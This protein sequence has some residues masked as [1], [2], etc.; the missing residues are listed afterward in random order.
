MQLNNLQ[1]F[2][3]SKLALLFAAALSVLALGCTRKQEN[4]SQVIVRLPVSHD[5]NSTSNNLINPK[6]HFAKIAKLEAM[7]SADWGIAHPASLAETKCFAVVV[8]VPTGTTSTLSTPQCAIDSN[9]EKNITVS[10]FAGLAP[11]GSEIELNVAAGPDRTF[12]LFAF[13]AES[14]GDCQITTVGSLI[15]KS[16]LSGPLHIG[17]KKA[18]I[19]SGVNNIEI[20]GSFALS[21][22]YDNCEWQTPPPLTGGSLA[23]N[24]GAAYTNSATVTV[25]N[26]LPFVASEV[27]YTTNPTCSTGGNWEQYSPIKAG[28]ALAV[29]DGPKSIYAKFRDS[30]GSVS[31]CLSNAIILDQTSPN[32]TLNPAPDVNALSASNF[33]FNGTCSDDGLTITWTVGTVNGSTVCTAN[34]FSVSGI[35]VSALPDGTATVSVSTVDL[36]S[37]MGTGSDAIIKDV[38]APTVTIA[39]PINASFVNAT[40]ALSLPVNGTCSENGAIVNLTLG[41]T[42]ASAPCAGGVYSTNVNVV[43]EIDGSLPIAAEIMDGV[44]NYGSNTVLVTKDTTPPTAVVTGVPTSI[45][46]GAGVMLNVDPSDVVQYRFAVSTVSQADCNNIGNYG[47]P[48]A[49]A[50]P[51]DVSTPTP[52]LYFVCVLG[53]DFAG[54]QQSVSTPTIERLTKGPV[55]IA[56]SQH[57]STAPESVG[58]RNLAIEISPI[59]S[60]PVSL[61]VEVKGTALNGTHYTGFIN[62]RDTI[63]VPALTSASTVDVNVIGSSVGNFEK[64]LSVSLKG[65]PNTA[66]VQIGFNQTHEVW[67]E[68]GAV[69]PDTLQK[70]AAGPNHTCGISNLGKLF[71]WGTDANGNLGNG[72]PNTDESSPV[73]TD[74]ANTYSQVSVNNHSTCGIRTDQTLWCWGANNNGMLGLGDTTSRIVPTLV[75]NNFAKVSVG[76]SSTCAINTSG[77]LFCW[78]NQADGRLGNGVSSGNALTPQPIAIGGPVSDVSTGF[79]HAC[80]VRTDGQLFCWGRNVLGQVGDGFTITRLSPVPVSLVNP[81]IQVSA[82]TSYTCAVLSTN[83]AYCWGNGSFGNLGQGATTNSSLPIG[84]H[85]TFDFTSIQAGK[86]TTCAVSASDGRLKCWGSGAFGLLG[87]GVIRPTSFIPVD[88]RLPSTSTAFSSK[89]YTACA[90]S[91]GNGFCWGY[92]NLG[93]T[94]AGFINRLPLME[95]SPTVDFMQLSLGRGGCGITPSNKLWCWGANDFNSSIPTGQVG[96]GTTYHRNGMVHVDPTESYSAVSFGIRHTCGITLSNELKCWGYNLD[97]QLGTGDTFGHSSPRSIGFSYSAV[98]VGLTSTCAINVANKLF[99][100]G[101]NTYGQLGTG[102]NTNRLMPEPVMPGSDFLTVIVGMNHACAITTS[103]DLYCW[104]RNNIGQV[105]DSTTIDRNSPQLIQSNVSKISAGSELTC[106]IN[107][108]NQLYCMGRN[109]SGEIGQGSVTPTLYA[110]PT[111]V[112]PGYQDVKIGKNASGGGVHVCGRTTANLV[113]CWGSNFRGQN[114]P[115]VGNVLSPVQIDAGT[116]IEVETGEWQTCVRSISGTWSC[117]GLIEESQI[118]TLGFSSS[119]PSLLPRVRY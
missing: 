118:P 33:G 55:T 105:G 41:G 64:R 38:I 32:I 49:V 90:V 11:A 60:T 28:Y 95:L 68:D 43:S 78:G 94:G 97:G 57:W 18:N 25:T 34:T 19:V 17:S 102:N 119:I 61:D 84:A 46:L 23:I 2:R 8:E 21:T 117:R 100:W 1:K 48:L 56:F 45:V 91:G 6:D 40:A 108:T 54:N 59:L 12:H 9:P 98:S 67:I 106:Y 76:I 13:A 65:S 62:G 96:D 101:N 51:I 86:Q 70:I 20:T 15:R 36:A 39:Q 27:Y 42:L 87:D 75:G 72:G 73:P 29:G 114:H 5:A 16:S 112:G 69:A 66:G 14:S 99:C 24:A 63:T 93:Q 10:Q 111:L 52:A 53:I 26:S 88:V 44:G 47:A 83:K 79:D 30:S 4:G 115:S 92:N 110:I 81:A 80:A 50:T 71:C 104:G 103:Q 82:G 7:S 35:D 74:P 31:S 116:F 113:N 107:A 22:A 58:F 109:S 85:P 3:R 37:N 77:N 89:D